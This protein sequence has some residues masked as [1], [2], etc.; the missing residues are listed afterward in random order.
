L[1]AWE[2]V[3]VDEV[4]RS[5][6]SFQSGHTAVPPAPPVV[7]PHAELVPPAPPAFVPEHSL[8]QSALAV[9]LATSPGAPSPPLPPSPPRPP[10][11]PGPPV[12]GQMVLLVRRSLLFE[13]RIQMA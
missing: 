13:L 2:K 5:M 6:L 10:T 1:L 9:S 3:E 12:P 8:K 11:R 4:Q 7:P